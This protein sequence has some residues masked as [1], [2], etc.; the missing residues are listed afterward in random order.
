M[1]NNITGN[2]VKYKAKSDFNKQLNVI[3]GEKNSQILCLRCPY[4]V[5]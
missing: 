2:T 5:P 4:I 3:Y 1:H